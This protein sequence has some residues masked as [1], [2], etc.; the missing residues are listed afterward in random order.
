MFTK[1]SPLFQYVLR[2]PVS[3][4]SF[5]ALTE[6]ILGLPGQKDASY[7][8][9]ANVHM[10]VEAYQHPAFEKIVA[11]ADIVTPDGMPVAM[12]VGW[13]RRQPQDRV[14]GMDFLPVLL[15][16]AAARK[17]TVFLYGASDEVL[18]TIVNKASQE[19]PDLEVVGQYA[20][21]FRPL[22][23]QE[24]RDV[25]NTINRANPDFLLVALGC[26][27]QEIWM[28]NHQGQIHSCMLGLGGA[29][30]TYAGM[31]QRPPRWVQQA[32]LEWAYRLLQDP[33]RLWRR[34]FRTNFRFIWLIGRQMWYRRLYG[35]PSFETKVQAS[36]FPALDE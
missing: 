19:Y 15:R 11:D 22:T 29:F 35:T 6:Q 5:G 28:A 4:G 7:V 14:A 10:L 13:L 23:P 36:G 9:F 26:P 27:K 32:A 3:V 24:D 31:R 2:T 21:P 8:C 25:V 33:R 20:P 30:L 17:K 18:N 16:E 1:I 34:Y 12:A